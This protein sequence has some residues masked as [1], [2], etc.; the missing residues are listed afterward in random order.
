MN[1]S[2]NSKSHSS[3]I[4]DF[5][6]PAVKLE[7][8]CII[9]DVDVKYEQEEEISDCAFEINTLQM[10]LSEDCEILKTMPPKDMDSPPDITQY[11]IKDEDQFEV[12]REENK[13]FETVPESPDILSE[14][15]PMSPASEAIDIPETQSIID[16]DDETVIYDPE[17][18]S[19]GK[20]K[21]NLKILKDI[22]GKI[23]DNAGKLSSSSQTEE[24]V[25]KKLVEFLKTTCEEL[26]ELQLE[27][28][29]EKKRLEQ[30]AIVK[31]MF[32]QLSDSVLDS[33]FEDSKKTARKASAIVS[34]TQGDSEDDSDNEVI[35][36]D[37]ERLLNFDSLLKKPTPSKAAKPKQSKKAVKKEK[38]ELSG[39]YSSLSEDD[40]SESE[41]DDSDE[42]QDF[43]S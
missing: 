7:A 28:S 4:D 22:G 30:E 13:K 35:D 11:S 5:L 20:M 24:E 34:S 14:Y 36:K 31:Q 42:S 38:V 2:A 27:V 10:P 37:V 19:L 29:G 26:R 40:G 8:E 21:A 3:V 15:D 9:D 12:I 1:V 33:S 41:G 17:A 43:V 18:E 25:K 32:N 6:Y 23:S 16:D 39:S